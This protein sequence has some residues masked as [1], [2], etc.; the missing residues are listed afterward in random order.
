[1]NNLVELTDWFQAEDVLLLT[2]YLASQTFHGDP[3]EAL[4]FQTTMPM[5]HGRLHRF[6]MGRDLH[7]TLRNPSVGPWHVAA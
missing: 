2:L 1:M 7:L 3:A 4:H 6:R 5:C